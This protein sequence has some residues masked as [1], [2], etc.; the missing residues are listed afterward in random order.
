MEFVTLAQITLHRAG[1]ASGHG[2][3]RQADLSS[4]H[5]VADAQAETLRELILS[6]AEKHGD[7]RESLQNMTQAQSYDIKQRKVTIF[8]SRGRSTQYSY[9]YATCFAF[10][11]LKINKRYFKLE[12]VE[13]TPV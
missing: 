2:L 7:P 8:D 11:A 3:V 5:E 12:E 1:S 13:Q 4:A 10:P 9:P 6:I